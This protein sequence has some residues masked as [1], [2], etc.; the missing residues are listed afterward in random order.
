MFAGLAFNIVLRL[1]RHHFPKT[2]FTKISG[3][4]QEESHR[5]Y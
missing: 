1:Y 4:L 5:I 2:I 3:S